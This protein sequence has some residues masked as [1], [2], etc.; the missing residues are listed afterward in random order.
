MSQPSADSSGDEDLQYQLDKPTGVAY[1]VGRLDRALRRSFRRVLDPLGLTLGQYT[2]LSVFSS[3]GK[4]SNAK[5]AERTMVSPQAA[6]ELIKG[7]EKKGWIVRK[8]D[9]N[10]GRIIHISLTSEGKRL[11]SRCD[12]VIAQIER[13]MLHDLSDKEIKTLHGKLRNAVGVLREL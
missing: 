13:Q 4:L 1:M 10:H 6:N 12:R 11:L 3:S 2:A 7:M 9:P 5:L 8:P